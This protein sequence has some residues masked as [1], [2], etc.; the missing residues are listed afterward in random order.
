MRILK[1]MQSNPSYLWVI[2][3]IS[4][5][6]VLTV[7][8][9]CSSSKSIYISPVCN[10]LGISRSAFSVNDSCRYIATAVVNIFFGALIAKFGAKKLILAGFAS[11]IASMLIYSQSTNVF[12]FYIGGIFLG[13]GLSWTT[14][15]MVGSVINKWCKKIRVQ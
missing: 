10:A 13:I 14:T 7:L 15:T 6:M 1:K 11:L 8:G 3:S 4:C 9:F 5:L 12:G 2:V